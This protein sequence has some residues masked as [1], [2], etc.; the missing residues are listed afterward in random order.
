M[1]VAGKN[2]QH[3]VIL[4]KLFNWYFGRNALPYW[5]IV[6]VDLMVCFA[7]GFLVMLMRHPIS[8]VLANGVGLVKDFLV[9][10]AFN[11]LGFRLFHTYSGILRYSQFIDLMRVLY[12]NAVAF[13]LALAFMFVAD[14]LSKPSST[15][16]WWTARP[17]MPWFM[18]RTKA[19]LP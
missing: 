10:G 6:I 2:L 8:D 16:H 12:A 1:E 4:R 5:C 18:A 13:V 9:F 15:T 17:R 19:P 7:S 11:L 14:Y 3:M